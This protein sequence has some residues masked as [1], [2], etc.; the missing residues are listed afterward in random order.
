MTTRDMTLTCAV[1]TMN[2]S[3][4]LRACLR[5]IVAQED[6]PDSILVVDNGSSDVT[7]A[8]VSQE[9]PEAKLIGLPKNLGVAQGRNVILEAVETDLVM[10]IDDDGVLDPKATAVARIFFG[11]P[12][13]KDVAVLSLTLRDPETKKIYPFE[14]NERLLEHYTYGCG[15]CVH[16]MKHLGAD[17]YPG[18]FWES[19]SEFDLALRLINQGY[20]IIKHRECIL[21]HSSIRYVDKPY[22]LRLRTAKNG[23]S[24][25]VRQFPLMYVLPKIA[26]ECQK[27]LFWCFRSPYR[28]RLLPD[29]LEIMGTCFRNI[30]RREP[31]N[32]AAFLRY[33]KLARSLAVSKKQS[34]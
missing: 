15:S 19:G 4:E 16:S 2:R 30:R 5:S 28:G 7:Y 13:H 21:W 12:E 25:A 34:S 9:Y 26:R 29:M 14:T 10:M 24:T 3:D 17:R 8:M 22:H 33:R 1:L 32:M 20:R 27:Y 31:V 18:E 11:E 23:C 6:K